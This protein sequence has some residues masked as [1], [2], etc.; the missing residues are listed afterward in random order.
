[1]FPSSS[2]FLS[3]SRVPATAVTTVIV[4][5]V[6]TRG[7]QRRRWGATTVFCVTLHRGTRSSALLTTILAYE[8]WQRS[9]SG[10]GCGWRVLG[11][12]LS[13]L[14]KTPEELGFEWFIALAC[15][16]SDCGYAFRSMWREVSLCQATFNAHCQIRQWRYYWVCFSI[17]FFLIDWSPM[18]YRWDGVL[19]A[20][21]DF[22]VHLCLRKGRRLM[23]HWRCR[24]VFI[25]HSVCRPELF[26][27]LSMVG[28]DILEGCSW[29][30]VPSPLMLAYFSG[31]VFSRVAAARLPICIA[32]D[33]LSV[34]TAF[35]F[36][37]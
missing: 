25:I 16:E 5:E 34:M 3:V 4:F 11:H 24:N 21:I 23:F 26:V 13:Y 7:S 17:L 30:L 32:E 19:V 28:I 15:D 20:H 6:V 31:N 37:N 29:L 35:R 10:A 9:T 12:P 1:M 36:T 8:L 14:A 18:I 2:W 22:D 27:S 33:K